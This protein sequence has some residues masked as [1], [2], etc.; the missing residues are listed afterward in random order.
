MIICI[1]DLD[2]DIKCNLIQSVNDIRLG[3]VADV[4]NSSVQRDQRNLSIVPTVTI[5]DH[6]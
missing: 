5:N 4:I 1:K 6:K 2:D 3:T